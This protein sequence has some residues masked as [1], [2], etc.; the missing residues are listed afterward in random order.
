MHICIIVSN[1]FEP[2]RWV[3]PMTT[4]PSRLFQNTENHVGNKYS[5]IIKNAKKIIALRQFIQRLTKLF[6]ELLTKMPAPITA[7]K[8]APIATKSQTPIFGSCIVQFQYCILLLNLPRKK[9]KIF[10]SN[11]R[12]NDNYVASKRSNY[13]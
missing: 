4:P 1:T 10:P 11:S 3:A 13:D 7:A 9:R 6:D 8:Y 5:A 2:K 12:T